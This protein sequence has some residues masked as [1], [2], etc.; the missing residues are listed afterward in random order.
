[1]EN[2]MKK[3]IDGFTLKIIALILMVFDHVHYFFVGI[4]DV[5]T[6]FT[7]LGRLA[8]P[9]FIYMT[10]VGMRHT[11]NPKK[12]ILRLYTG[13]LVMA[14]GNSIMNKYFPL[15]NNSI[16]I[17]NIFGTLFII[18]LMIYAIQKISENKGNVKQILKYCF[19]FALPIISSYAFNIALTM[20]NML[21][22]KF[23]MTFLPNVMFCEGGFMWIV[24]GIGFYL[25][26]KTKIKTAIFYLVFCLVDL[27]LHYNSTVGLESM[28]VSNIQWMMVFSL[29]FILLYNG[30]RGKGLKYFFYIF[31]PAH[32]YLLAIASFFLTKM[33]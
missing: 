15:P 23:T 3:G 20:Q 24:L 4:Y 2:I 27:L 12:Y 11:R 22:T 30:Q 32:I 33:F 16:V 19:V 13:S 6:W 17:N 28:F 31:Y 21:I 29:P 8:A 1:M 7:M 10:A 5:P 14:I 26:R 25:C 18:A 9:L